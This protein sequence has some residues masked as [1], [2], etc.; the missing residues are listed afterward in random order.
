MMKNIR[1]VL[2]SAL[3]AAGVLFAQSEN[4]FGP[5]QGGQSESAGLL[6]P[7][8]ITVNH[9]ISFSAGGQSFSNMK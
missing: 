1:T 2:L 5:T 7:S 4:A 8:R 3:F 9:A 6:D